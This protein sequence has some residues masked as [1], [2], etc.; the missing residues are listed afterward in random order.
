MAQS[1][2]EIALEITPKQRF[3]VIDIKELIN[4][5]KCGFEKNFNFEMVDDKLNEEEKEL[6][7]K[8]LKEKYSTDAWNLKTLEIIN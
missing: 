5:V 7:K 1:I 3:D 4:A 6:S 8:L 2:N